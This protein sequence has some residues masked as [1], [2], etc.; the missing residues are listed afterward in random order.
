[1]IL[2]QV[3]S[4]EKHCVVNSPGNT[5][6]VLALRSFSKSRFRVW[7][8]CFFFIHIRTIGKFRPILRTNI[9]FESYGCIKSKK[10]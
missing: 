5:E 1:M 10:I 4:L 9:Y 2:D 6:K 8:A 7:M 3:D